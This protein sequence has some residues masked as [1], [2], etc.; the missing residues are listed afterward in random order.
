M[1][2]TEGEADIDATRR[3]TGL[4]LAPIDYRAFL[5]GISF[6]YV[7]PSTPVPRL[8]ASLL[9]RFDS[10]GMSFEFLNTR[11]PPEEGARKE[12]LRSV[13]HVRKQSTLALAMII[14]RMVSDV[15]PG[16]AY[17]NIGV[18]HGFTLFAGMAGNPDKICIGVDNGPRTIAPDG[19][20]M[21][22]FRRW[23]SE[24]H[25]FYAMGYEEYFARV[26]RDPIGFYLYDADHS[27]DHQLQNLRLAE[28]YFTEHCV[29]MIDD[30]NAA[31]VRQATLDFLG[32]S[33]NR[34]ETLLDVRTPR[35]R[36]PTFWNGAMLMRRIR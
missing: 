30:A 32:S 25:R 33:R 7:R 11:V 10:I 9:R 21:R 1:G 31:P 16:A 28:P 17:L 26:H 13:F 36:H 35:D 3:G 18:L 15:P 14:N 29:V 22:R 12:R 23:K 5:D 4:T 19:P 8:L 27:Y 20:F 34:Y 24:Q 6:R 2:R